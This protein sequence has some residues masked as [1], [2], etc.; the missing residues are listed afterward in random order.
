MNFLNT[1]MMSALNESKLYRLCLINLS[2]T[3]QISEL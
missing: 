3:M 2:R 1:T